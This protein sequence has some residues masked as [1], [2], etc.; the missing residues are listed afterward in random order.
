MILIFVVRNSSDVMIYQAVPPKRLHLLTQISLSVSMRDKLAHSFD[1]VQDVFLSS[2]RA[3]QVYRIDSL[4][5]PVYLGAAAVI[6]AGMNEAPCI[7]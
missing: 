7:N 2:F 1:I 4:Q 6:M 5:P 3:R